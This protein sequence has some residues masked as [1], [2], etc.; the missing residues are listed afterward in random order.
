MGDRD[1]HV[2][3]GDQILDLEARR[4]LAGDDLGPPRVAEALLQ[5]IELVPDEFQDERAVGEDLPVALDPRDRLCVLVVD[6]LPLETGQPL[7]PHLE[8]RLGLLLR[9]TECLQQP[10]T[11]RLHV[12]GGPDQGDHRV[13][14]V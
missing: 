1:D 11:R 13:E 9:E 7:Q 4:L 2:L 8:N 14:L 12:R 5:R 6:L 3:V 10:L